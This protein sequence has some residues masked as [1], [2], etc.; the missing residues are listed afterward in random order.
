VNKVLTQTHVV[1]GDNIN[2][3]GSALLISIST[4]FTGLDQEVNGHTTQWNIPPRLLLV[5]CTDGGQAECMA[6]YTLRR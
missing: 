4:A 3:N 5:L 2:S 6:A 1:L